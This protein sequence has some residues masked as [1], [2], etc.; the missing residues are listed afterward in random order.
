MWHRTLALI[1][2]SRGL[3][4]RSPDVAGNPD[5]W[6]WCASLREVLGVDARQ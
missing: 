2:H 5:L 6:R 3:L 4:A 1:L